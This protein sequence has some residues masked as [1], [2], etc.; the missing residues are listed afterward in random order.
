MNHLFLIIPVF[1]IYILWGI[2]QKSF[3]SPTGVLFGTWL[4][5]STAHLI[6]APDYIFT[7]VSSVLITT[8]LFV[9]FIGEYL[10]SKI[11]PFRKKTIISQELLFSIERKRKLETQLRKITIGISLVSLA[12]ASIYFLIFVNH[13]G[14]IS[15][16]LS[17]GW[18]IR[19]EMAIGA[20]SV[21][22][23]VRS[24]A[25]LSY[26]AILLSMVY[27]V[28][29]GPRFFIILPFLSIFIM[30]IAQAARAGTFMIIIIIFIS[31]CWRDLSTYQKYIGLIILKR[32][33]LFTVFILLIFV[34]GLMF[35]EQSFYFSIDDFSKLLS[36]RL[37]ALGAISS[38]SSF[39]D[40]HDFSAPLTWGR[41]SFA[42]F[43]QLLGLYDFDSFGYYDDYLYISNT[44]NESTN[45]YT[46]FRSLIEDFG[47]L[48][49]FILMF[50]LG[51]ISRIAF[52][53]AI[54]GNLAALSFVISM[55]TM[56]VYS[57]IAPMTQHNSI[58][59]SWILPPIILFL[60]KINTNKST[61]VSGL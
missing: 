51:L 19:E 29:F 44:S 7:L 22:L 46:I 48:G 49:S 21:P 53:S 38:F 11:N 9:F 61:V 27:W 52:N 18:L 58:I 8:F 39:L 36:F 15:G 12:G 1:F 32:I 31:S 23:Y 56:F 24:T 41:Y 26:S 35:R 57:P 59:I 13:F 40:Q 54:K 14:S 20:I 5:F 47:I 37:Y 34:A 33:F 28:R 30:G 43:F 17:A 6:L 3:F 55:Y 4:T 60:L 45:I 50:L 25:L 2:Y 42:S 10:G 16:L